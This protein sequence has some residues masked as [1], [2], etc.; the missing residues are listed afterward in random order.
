MRKKAILALGCTLTISSLSGCVPSRTIENSAYDIVDQYIYDSMRDSDDYFNPYEEKQEIDRGI[1]KSDL[2]DASQYKPEYATEP[3]T[4]ETSEEETTEEE[5]TAPTTE[6]SRETSSSNS[7]S[8]GDYYVAPTTASYVE[9]TAAEEPTRQSGNT[10][11]IVD[12]HESSSSTNSSGTTDDSSSPEKRKNPASVVINGSK[13]D[14]YIA[15]DGYYRGNKAKSRIN[16]YNSNHTIEYDTDYPTGYEPVIVQFTVTAGEN[17]PNGE[18]YLVPDIRV[19]DTSG[20][21]FNEVAIPVFI[22]RLG[23]Y[24][25]ENSKTKSYD[26]VFEIPEDAAGFQ[27]LFGTSNGSTYRFKSTALDE[28]YDD[29]EED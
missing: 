14:T 5:T 4:E 1:N 13:Y 19:R 21:S 15:I 22:M 11:S 23:K 20:A 25:D 29:E 16:R 8:G 24:N 28:N 27:V 12:T 17:T 6:A 7:S 18:A 9:S 10:S 26:A 3:S 2:K